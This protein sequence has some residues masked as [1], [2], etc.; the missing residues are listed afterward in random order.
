MMLD[1]PQADI[2]GFTEQNGTDAC[3]EVMGA[4]FGLTDMSELI[5]KAGFCL[6]FQK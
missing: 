4:C 2:T 3:G 6:N 1:C 5:S